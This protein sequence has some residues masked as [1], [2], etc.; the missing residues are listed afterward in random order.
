MKEVVPAGS[1]V[2][3]ESHDSLAMARAL[4]NLQAAQIT[5]MSRVMLQNRH[6][7]VQS[8]QLGSLLDVYQLALKKRLR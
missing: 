4:E 8:A 3:A 2:F 5:T 1:Y 7:V 6:L